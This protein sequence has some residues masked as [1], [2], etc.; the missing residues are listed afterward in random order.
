MA[1][2]IEILPTTAPA[3]AGR[4]STLA[5]SFEIRRRPPEMVSSCAPAS[6]LYSYPSTSNHGRPFVL[7]RTARPN[8]SP[9][10]RFLSTSWFSETPGT[11]GSWVDCSGTSTIEPCS[12]W[13]SRSL[14]TRMLKKEFAPTANRRLS[15]FPARSRSMV[16]LPFSTIILARVPLWSWLPAVLR[17][18][19][20][21][22]ADG[23]KYKTNGSTIVVSILFSIVVPSVL[24]PWEVK[25]ESHYLP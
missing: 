1:A 7:F 10:L 18:L 4:P 5:N 15:A 8:R 24:L 3:S 12:G 22:I 20:D 21:P 11:E 19:P 16:T 17:E 13:R 2:P 25:L 9:D 6:Y 23:P 14:N